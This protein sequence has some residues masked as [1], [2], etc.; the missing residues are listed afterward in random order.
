MR[1]TK[2]VSTISY[3]SEAFLEG[4]LNAL[5][6]AHKIA[7]WAYIRHTAEEDEHKDH[8]HVYIEPN[9]KVDTMDLQ[10]LL[11]EVDVKNPGKPLK[12][13]DWRSS[14]WDDWY[15]YGI[16]Y[17]PY[18]TM[19]FESRKYHYQMEDVKASDREDLDSRVHRTMHSDILKHMRIHTAMVNG[20]T[21]EKLVF[22]GAIPPSQAFA[23][24]NWQH[25]YR[26]GEAQVKYGFESI[27]EVDVDVPFLEESED[28][29][30]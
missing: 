21:V 28:K 27:D 20:M 11:C 6:K 17:E 25:M 16:H 3:N 1:T 26:R 5:V 24:A 30:E 13:V 8:L 2:P 23:Y 18:L 10:E 4:T 19:K 15:L 7:F 12:C 29:N 14:K 9:G 22:N